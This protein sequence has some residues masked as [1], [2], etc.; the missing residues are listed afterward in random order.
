MR[1]AEGYRDWLRQVVLVRLPVMA[2]LVP[3]SKPRL[4]LAARRWDQMGE[5]VDA[6]ASPSMTG[7]KSLCLH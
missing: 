1:E 5:D 3:A 6:G 2:G 4:P 7:E